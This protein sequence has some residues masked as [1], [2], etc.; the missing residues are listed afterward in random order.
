MLSPNAEEAFFINQECFQDGP[1]SGKVY[2]C[3]I[4]GWL[5]G[6]RAPAFHYIKKTE[7]LRSKGQ[8]LLVNA[9]GAPVRTDI[10]HFDS[11]LTQGTHLSRDRQ[12]R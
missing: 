2:S 4:E 7:K 11:Q 1:S 9:A 12:C 8:E 5:M 6:H 3:Q 10:L